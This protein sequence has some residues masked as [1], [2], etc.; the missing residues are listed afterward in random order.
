M[1]IPINFRRTKVSLR[2]ACR[3]SNIINHGAGTMSVDAPAPWGGM[4]YADRGLGVPHPGLRD[5]H[6]GL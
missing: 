2:I 6:T 3:G 1:E 5:S 4:R